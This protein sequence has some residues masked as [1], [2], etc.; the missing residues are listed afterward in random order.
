MSNCNPSNSCNYVSNC[1]S[2]GLCSD[3]GLCYDFIIKRHDGLPE[4]KVEVTDCDDPIDLTGLVAEASMWV[5]SKL[6]ADITEEQ[7]TIKLADNIGFDLILE[8]TII[9]AGIG[10]N[11]ERMLVTGFDEIKKEIYVERGYKNTTPFPWKK[12]TPLRLLRFLSSSALTEMIYEDVTN[13]DGSIL[14]NQL[15]HSYLIYKWKPDD[16]CLAGC[17]YLEFKLLKMLFIDP[18]PPNI[19]YSPCD[20][21]QGV[22]WVRRFPNDK[23]GFVIQIYNSPTGE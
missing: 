2:D 3:L 8:G 23:E 4:F 6:K 5:N 17:F 18:Y 15:T 11:F 14:K 10:R 1:L 19:S 20:W 7:T 13:M 16:T 12:A 21:G 9:Q 22:E